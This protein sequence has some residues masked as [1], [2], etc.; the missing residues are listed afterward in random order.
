MCEFHNFWLR[1]V[2]ARMPVHEDFVNQYCK[3]SNIV[4][5]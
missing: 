2:V 4:W 1:Q 3:A 5:N